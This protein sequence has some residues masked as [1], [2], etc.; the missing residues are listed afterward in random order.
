MG[1]ILIG[2]AIKARRYHMNGESEQAAEGDEQYASIETG[3]GDTVIYDRT[4]EHAWVQSSHT[5]DIE[6]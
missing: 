2:R 3:D 6:A 4:N 1:L 5:V